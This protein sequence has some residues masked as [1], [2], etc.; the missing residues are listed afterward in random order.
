MNRFVEEI[1]EEQV[2][3]V[4]VGAVRLGDILEEDRADDAATAPH[5]RDL[6]LVELPAVVLGGVLDEHEALCVGDDLGGVEG[7]LEVVDKLLLV[8]VEFGDIWSFED[9]GCADTFGLERGEAASE[10]LVGSLVE[11]TEPRERLTTYSLTDQSDGHAEI[12][13]IDG[14]PL[15]GTFLAS[16]V[17]NLLNERSSIIIVEV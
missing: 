3:Q 9:A 5:E 4:R 12:E 10:D 16:R 11:Y 14:S 15:S 8:T 1:I 17:Q 13:G 7:L 2:L 6:G